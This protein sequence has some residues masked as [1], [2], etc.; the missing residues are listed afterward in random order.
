M[1]YYKKV[2]LT[3]AIRLYVFCIIEL[4]EIADLIQVDVHVDHMLRF[5]SQLKLTMTQNIIKRK[6]IL[7]HLVGTGIFRGYQWEKS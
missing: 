3:F 4:I 7:R 2:Y 5:D 1:L 6:Y